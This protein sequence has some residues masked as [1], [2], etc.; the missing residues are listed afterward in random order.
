MNRGNF[1]DYKPRSDKHRT[2]GDSRKGRGGYSRGNQRPDVRQKNPIDQTGKVS[3]CITCDSS[4]HWEKIA[5]TSI[6]L[7]K[8]LVEDCY[9]DTIVSETFSSALLDSSRTKTVCGTQWLREYISGLSKEDRKAIVKPKGDRIFKF[10]DGKVVNARERVIIPA[11]I[12][13]QKGV[14]ECEVIY[15]NISL[16]LSKDSMKKA[17]VTINFVENTT[18]INGAKTDLCTT[19]RGQYK[20]L[21]PSQEKN[22]WDIRYG[23]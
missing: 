15:K 10:G 6:C 11:T 23:R 16:L 1:S 20:S 8:K 12:G 17:G 22:P 9:F 7:L 14:I 2:R 18:T 21:K 13:S 5:H 4:M 3:R 19:S